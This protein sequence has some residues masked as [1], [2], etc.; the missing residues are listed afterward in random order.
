MKELE[1]NM[2]PKV[3]GLFNTLKKFNINYCNSAQNTYKKNNK[4]GTMYCIVSCYVLDL[5]IIKKKHYMVKTSAYWIF[6]CILLV[7]NGNAQEKPRTL[8]SNSTDITIIFN[9]TT[10]LAWHLQPEKNPDI[11]EIGSSIGHKKVKFITDIDSVSFVLKAGQ[12]INFPILLNG[13]TICHT[14]ISAL[15]DPYFFRNG[16]SWLIIFSII[17]LAIITFLK[18]EKINTKLLLSL[19]IIAP[20]SFWLMTFVGGFL[21]G[22]YHHFRNTVSTLGEISS[23][24]E[25]FMAISTLLLSIFCFL[26]SIGFYKASNSLQINKIPSILSFSLAVSMAWAAIFPAGHQ[27]HGSL[28]PL[29]ILTMMSV[30]LE[31]FLWKG[32]KFKLLRAFSMI[33]L[34]IMLLFLSRFISEIYEKNEGLIQRFF[35]LGWSV[36]S[37]GLGFYLRKMI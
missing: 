10:K 13:N 4:H 24:S 27:L 20:L 21:Y 17:F 19:G 5:R 35:Y 26:F 2:E 36:W 6:L 11:F 34:A 14:Q 22:N 12:K 32:E 37:I 29:P 7:F 1:I 3:L 25:I 8:R 31:I 15:Q 23:N 16:F 18:K 30:L 28:G 9:E 33:S